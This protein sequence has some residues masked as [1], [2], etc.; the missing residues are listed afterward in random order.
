DLSDLSFIRVDFRG[1]NLRRAKL[2]GSH[3]R[4]CDLRNANLEDAMLSRTTFTKCKWDEGILKAELSSVTVDQRQLFGPQLNQLFPT[5]TVPVSASGVSSAPDLSFQAYSERI[6]RERL[7]K[8]VRSGR[9]DECI[10]W[11]AFMGGTSPHDREF[12]V[13]KI[14]RALRTAGVV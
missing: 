13:R 3:F 6:M 8:F 12:V 10:S 5:H 2:S 11:I 9:V 14:Y 7:S 4:N 1:V